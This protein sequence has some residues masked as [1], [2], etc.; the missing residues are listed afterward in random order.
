MTEEEMVE[1]NNE[2]RKQLTKENLKYYE[3]ML[4]Y[5]RLSRISSKK[6]EELLL[7][8]LDHLLIAQ[9]EGRTA[10]DVFGPDP[11]AYCEEV[12]Q[13]MGRHS[14]LSFSRY[15]FI[16]SVGLYVV[17]LLDG[18]F[19]LIVEPLLSYFIDLPQREGF[20]IDWLIIPVF[21]IFLIEM[22]MFFLRKSTFKKWRWRMLLGLLPQAIIF[23]GFL[24]LFIYL[25]EMIP[26]LPIPA[27]ISVLIGSVLWG[28]HKVIFKRVELF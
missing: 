19:R 25:K 26:V 7:E 16:F 20:S 2:L 15:A 12:I 5:L 11:E 1:K 28:L 4:V 9:K 10:E 14:L 6:T 24:L 23:G 8:I 27:W 3:D 21:G 13:S 18:I 17:F 22:M